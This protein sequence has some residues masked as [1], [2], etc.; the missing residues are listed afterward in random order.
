MTET[1]FTAGPYFAVFDESIQVRSKKDNCRL[2]TL[3]HFKGPL[4]RFERIDIPEVEANAHLF[5]AAAE[6]Y[7]ELARVDPTN[8]VLAKA[9]GE[10]PR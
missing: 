4:L 10:A 2:A 7:R 8:P 6:L 9:R 3:H 5:A 1:K